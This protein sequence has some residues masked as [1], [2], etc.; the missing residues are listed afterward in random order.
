MRRRFRSHPLSGLRHAVA[1]EE[2]SDS[3]KV[4]R[5]PPV[6]RPESWPFASLIVVR[7]GQNQGGTAEALPPLWREGVVFCGGWPWCRNS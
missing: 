7:D 3:A 1:D 4:G 5:A 6:I 2:V